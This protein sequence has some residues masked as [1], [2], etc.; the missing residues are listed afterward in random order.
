MACTP[1]PT[2]HCAL[3][4][5]GGLALAA[6]DR[7]LGY[8]LLKLLL[9]DG[10]LYVVCALLQLFDLVS[11]LARLSCLTADRKVQLFTVPFE[12]CGSCVDGPRFDVEAVAE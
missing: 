11:V 1:D 10:L 3:A 5:T 12:L 4:P 7:D 8:G 9:L 2:F 6:V